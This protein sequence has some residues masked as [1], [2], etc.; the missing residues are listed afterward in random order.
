MHMSLT[1][2]YAYIL[3]HPSLNN[4]YIHVSYIIVLCLLNTG[5]RQIW[6]SCTNKPGEFCLH[7]YNVY[8][9]PSLLSS[10]MISL[11]QSTSIPCTVDTVVY[12]IIYGITS[13][14]STTHRATYLAGEMLCSVS[15]MVRLSAIL[16]QITKGDYVAEKYVTP[17]LPSG[18]LHVLS[19]CIMSSFSALI[20]HVLC[21][22]LMREEK[23]G[24]KKQARSNIQQG[25]AT[26]HTQGSHFS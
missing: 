11:G 6:S 26:Q 9:Q 16:T 5:T 10:F 4:M 25:K 21:T 13:H 18:A 3:L 12:T 24:R 2:L 1:H 15:D 20:K 8:T 19:T 23:E 14:L 22:C 17:T 7:Q